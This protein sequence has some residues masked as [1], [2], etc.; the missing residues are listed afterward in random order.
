MNIRLKLTLLLSALSAVI[1]VACGTFFLYSLNHYFT[2]RAG[3]ELRIHATQINMLL[4]GLPAD[5][6]SQSLVRNIIA[7]SGIRYTAFD[8]SNRVLFSVGT[9]CETPP[10]FSND[11]QSDGVTV[12]LLT[13]FAHSSNASGLLAHA[14]R[15]CLEMPILGEDS[16]F[17]G[18]RTKLIL[19]SIL[20]I[21]VVIALTW[22]LSAKLTAP[23]TEI[24]DIARQIQNGA[25]DRRLPVQGRDEFAQLASTLNAMVDRLNDDIAKLNK[26]GEIRSQFLGNV[27]H[28]L[29]T[30]LFALQ[31]MLETL[32]AGALEDKDVNRDFVARALA[33]TIR[34]DAL[35]RDLIEISRIESGEMKMSFRY[36]PLNS[37]LETIVEELSP[38]AQQKNLN[39]VFSPASPDLDV[40]AD[41]LWLKQAIVNMLE[42]A[43]KYTP[44]GSV[45]LAATMGD[46]N[47]PSPQ[48]FVSGSPSSAPDRSF[49]DTGKDRYVIISISDTG[50]GIP[51]EHL[52]RIFE[53]FYRVDR[54]RSRDAGG[55]GLGLAI[56]KHII[57]A[58][59][60]SVQVESQPGIGSKFSFKLG[61]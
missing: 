26:L 12:F 37:F 47:T 32:L 60:S 54:E 58:H 36:V 44:T 41:R 43:L 5:S 56:V 48:D 8:S 53:R 30:P 22:M 51:V 46:G 13:P 24:V 42:N 40:Y 52:P 61:G 59:G 35:L 25:L 55:T 29:R 38:L 15:V 10:T 39:L 6:A 20:L 1:I 28:E 7:Q 49:S 45:T 50:L 17:L 2:M 16:A 9:R 33:N 57:E 27:S 19:A 14:S 23:I 4:D 31:G 18:I 11:V 34:L 21:T 3:E